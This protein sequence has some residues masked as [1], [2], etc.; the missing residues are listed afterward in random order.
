MKVDFRD[1]DINAELS[2]AENN[3]IV[4]SASQVERLAN[5]RQQRQRGIALPW[6]KLSG[7][8][9]IHK[10]QLCLLGGFSGH[11]KT[12]LSTQIALHAMKQGYRVGI[13]SLELEV[14]EL[15]EQFLSIASGTEQPP[16]PWCEQALQWADD[17]LFL[18]DRID[19]IT[20]DEA[21]QMIIAFHKFRGCDLVV[22][23]A[24]MMTG[25]CQDTE[26]EQQFSQTVAAVAKKFNIAVL[27]LHHMRKP[28]GP[29][30]EHKVPG[31]Y[32][33]IGSS[34]LVNIAHSVLIGWH[35]KKKAAD[36]NNGKPVD[37]NDPD[38]VLSVAKQRSG[39]YEGMAGLWLSRECRA[40]CSTSQ[41]RVAPLEFNGNAITGGME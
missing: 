26:R 20:P 19:A 3:E 10:G 12:T 11:Y 5:F 8:F 13:A 14:P 38:Y 7:R 21:I 1:I 22:L 32:D 16:M 2:A 24:L 4:K 33:F 29:E 40:F 15:L 9:E 6:E 28:H 39:R 23:D 37:D 17:K 25:V 31:K 34:H 41:R 18:Y 27:M 36:F 30:G 35:N